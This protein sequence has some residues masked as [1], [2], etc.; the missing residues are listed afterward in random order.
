MKGK[1]KKR[2]KKRKRKKKKKKKKEI[3]TENEGQVGVH[4]ARS[5]VG[6]VG[7][8]GGVAA[9]VRTGVRV[10]TRCF[11]LRLANSSDFLKSCFQRFLCFS[12][13]QNHNKSKTCDLYH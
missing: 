12:R 7:V 11:R 1:R 6:A 3:L 5:D 10:V 8:I 13:L 9:S 2:K 4:I